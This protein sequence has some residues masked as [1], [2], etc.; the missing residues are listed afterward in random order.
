MGIRKLQVGLQEVLAIDAET[1]TAV[2]KGTFT[3][4]T[5][6]FLNLKGQ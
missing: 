4:I 2:A 6:S 3:R 5:Y 1:L